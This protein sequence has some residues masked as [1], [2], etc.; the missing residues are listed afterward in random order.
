MPYSNKTNGAGK[1]RA[2]AA[3][4]AAGLTRR[5]QADILAGVLALAGLA[6]GLLLLW[7]P[8]HAVCRRRWSYLNQ[9]RSFLSDSGKC[10]RLNVTALR[11]L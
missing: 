1:R 6:L 10:R 3:N 11:A 2:S 5:Q 9:A 8:K 4:A 7:Q